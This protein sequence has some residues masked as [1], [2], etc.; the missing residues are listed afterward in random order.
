ML[1]RVWGKG[2]PPTLLTEMK[3]GAD[4]MDNMM[5]DQQG[6]KQNYY[7]IHQFH[8]RAYIHIKVS[9]KETPLWPEEHSSQ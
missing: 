7:M 2:N 3:I 4:S 9:F 8:L 5:Q 1:G 6:Y